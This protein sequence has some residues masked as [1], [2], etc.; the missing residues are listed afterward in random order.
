LTKYCNPNPNS[1]F[2]LYPENAQVAWLAFN[3]CEATDINDTAH[4]TL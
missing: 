1:R 4:T 2:L 3:M